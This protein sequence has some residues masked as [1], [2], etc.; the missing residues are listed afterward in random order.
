MRHYDV[1]AAAGFH[2]AWGWPRKDAFLAPAGGKILKSFRACADGPRVPPQ[3][4]SR[5]IA[6]QWKMRPWSPALERCQE[7]RGH[8]TTVLGSANL[9]RKMQP[10][11]FSSCERRRRGRSQKEETRHAQGN[12]LP[13]LAICYLQS[14]PNASLDHRGKTTFPDLHAP[15]PLPF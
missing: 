1:A 7:P 14:M 2:R 12:S 4:K 3:Q 13:Y 10:F 15:A 9:W 6:G 5:V 8:R 11:Q